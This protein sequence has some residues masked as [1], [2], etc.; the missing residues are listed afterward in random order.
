MKDINLDN[1]FDMF[2]Y[3][4]KVN[5]VDSSNEMD[6]VNLNSLFNSDISRL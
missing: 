1:K 6:D 3:D 5:Y 4:M 2:Y